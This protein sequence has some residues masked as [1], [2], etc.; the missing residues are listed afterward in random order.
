[1]GVGP[2]S[3]RACGAGELTTIVGERGIGVLIVTR[4]A[5]R[6]HT[7]EQATRMTNTMGAQEKQATRRAAEYISE[8]TSHLTRTV[9]ARRLGLSEI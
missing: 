3:T 5:Q 4:K 8:C 2:V 1:M 9:S 7:D 6:R